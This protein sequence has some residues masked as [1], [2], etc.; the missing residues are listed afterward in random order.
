[1]SYSML[2]GQFFFFF[3]IGKW[4][5]SERTTFHRQN[6]VSPQRLESCGWAIL[7]N[8]F[9]VQIFLH[10]HWSRPKLAC[11]TT[12]CGCCHRL[13]TLFLSMSLCFVSPQFKGFLQFFIPIILNSVPF[14]LSSSPCMI[15]LPT[16]PPGAFL[17]TLPQ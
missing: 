9:F 4:I 11:I 13:L 5:Y 6:V 1:M 3:P 12:H 14:S 7:K 2:D 10:S 8:K 16:S 17:Q 15:P